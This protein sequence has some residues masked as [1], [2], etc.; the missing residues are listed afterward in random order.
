MRKAMM[1]IACVSLM[2]AGCSLEEQLA[3]DK[4]YNIKILK[5]GD[6]QRGY[7]ENGNDFTVKVE[8]FSKNGE[9]IE[10]INEIE[11]HQ[12][13][14]RVISHGE[15]FEILKPVYPGNKWI[16]LTTIVFPPPDITPQSS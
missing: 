10:T 6:T 3:G 16:Y 4:E 13:H 8:V 1:L 9:H 15:R 2:L 12:K 5:V 14:N 11:P 7:I